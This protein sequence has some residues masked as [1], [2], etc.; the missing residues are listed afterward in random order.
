M[1]RKSGELLL[2]AASR[3]AG[4]EY[5]SGTED[6]EVTQLGDAD[7]EDAWDD[8]IEALKQSED[9]G[10]VRA[11]KLPTDEDGNPRQ[12]KGTRQ[13][14]LGA[15]AHQLYSPK[16]LEA[17]IVREF[18]KPGEIAHVKFMGTTSGRKGVMFSRIVTLQRAEEPAQDK[19]TV[20]GLFKLMQDGQQQQVQVLREIIQPVAPA[21]L[22]PS[23]T[24]A[25]MGRVLELA[26][27]TL[28]TIL[29]ALIARP[30]PQS[31]I[32]A[33]IGAM[34]EMKSFITGEGGREESDSTAVAIVKAV[35]PAFPELLKLMA[36]NS[37]PVGTVQRRLPAPDGSRPTVARTVQATAMPSSTP[38]PIVAASKPTGD[39][40]VNFIELANQL[41]QLATLAEQKIDPAE[42]AKLVLTT[43]PP[44]YDESLA[45][46]VET[47]ANFARLGLLSP[48]MKL[49]A[50]WFENLRLALVQEIFEPDTVATV[51]TLKSV[52][53]APAVVVPG[54]EPTPT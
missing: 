19:E 6:A 8:W 40:D 32:G 18:L 21:Q 54:S 50:E 3:A 20:A 10:T 25:I 43:I 4:V 53:A 49:H 48:K 45:N 11:Y 38:P 7:S 46:L 47:P 42:V 26:I 31:D 1:A 15:W 34:S 13:I 41:E 37:A 5:T 36:Q 9:S 2:G 51:S 29:A 22:Q 12:G 23:Q 24:P 39:N 33:L 17:K 52:P 35:A 30:K 16:E 28:G 14:T 44:E 27:P